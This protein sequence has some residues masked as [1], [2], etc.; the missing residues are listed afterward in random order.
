MDPNETLRFA[1]EALERFQR[2]PVTTRDSVMAAMDLAEA[3][4][5]L[6]GWLSRGGFVPN[7]WWAPQAQVNL[8]EG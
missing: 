4:E 5:A 3:F 6:D 1:R 2:A 8:E 7:A